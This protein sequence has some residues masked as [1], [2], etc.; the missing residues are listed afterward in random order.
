[1]QKPKVTRLDF[2]GQKQTFKYILLIVVFVLVFMPFVT[3]FNDLLTRLVMSLDAYRVIQNYVVPWEV[4]MVGV[5]LYPFGFRPSIV[6]EYL[7]IGGSPGFAGQAGQSQFLIEIAWNCIGWQSLLFFL[8]TAFVGLQ[9][10]K[11]TNFSKVKAWIIGF[12]GTFLVNLLRIAVVALIAF[13]LGQNVAIVFHDYGSTLT[14]LA[15]LF[16]FW[17]FSYTFVLETKDAN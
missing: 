1:M 6:G 3:T 14:V 13:Y 17:W 15:W 5:L 12:L 7:A 11:Y 9:G 16:F 4:R 10:D 8:I 2:S